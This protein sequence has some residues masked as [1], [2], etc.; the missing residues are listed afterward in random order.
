M[1]R[2]GVDLYPEQVGVPLAEVQVARVR[3]DRE[4]FFLEAEKARIHAGLGLP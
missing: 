2:V 3:R 4:R 1:G